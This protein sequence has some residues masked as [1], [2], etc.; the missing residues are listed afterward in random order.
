MTDSHAARRSEMES[1]ERLGSVIMRPWMYSMICFLGG[2]CQMIMWK[3][4]GS[5]TY[6][7]SSSD[8]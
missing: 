2:A 4:Y 7:E 5:G 6:I 1:V 8:D 3:Q